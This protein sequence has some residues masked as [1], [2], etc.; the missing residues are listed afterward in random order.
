MTKIR[1]YQ[2]EFSGWTINSVI[3]KNINI[4]KYKTLS[5]SSYIKLSK[6]LNHSR[7]GLID[8]QNSDDNECLK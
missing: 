8:I 2:P 6:G 5:G 3:E 7:K 1:N 4:S